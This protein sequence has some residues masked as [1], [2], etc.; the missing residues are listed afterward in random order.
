MVDTKC[1]TVNRETDAESRSECSLFGRQAEEEARNR[2]KRIRSRHLSFFRCFRA[3]RARG[4]CASVCVTVIPRS[5]YYSVCAVGLRLL[6][7]ELG[8]PLH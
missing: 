7:M 2:R 4:V 3:A 8:F 6:D 1:T 5:R